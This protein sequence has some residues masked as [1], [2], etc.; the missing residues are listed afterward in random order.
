MRMKRKVKKENYNNMEIF[1]LIISI[2]VGFF[3]G[4]VFLWTSSVKHGDKKYWDEYY[5]KLNENRP[6]EV[7]EE[8]AYNITMKCYSISRIILCISLI[9]IAVCVYSLIVK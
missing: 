3:S 9:V 5:K 1:W 2:V 7:P 8:I 6:V 4:C